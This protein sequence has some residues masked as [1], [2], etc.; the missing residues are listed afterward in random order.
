MHECRLTWDRVGVLQVRS[1]VPRLTLDNV[2]EN[3]AGSNTVALPCCSGALES[4]VAVKATFES[5]MS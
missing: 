1:T 4:I 3:K 5:I 2:F